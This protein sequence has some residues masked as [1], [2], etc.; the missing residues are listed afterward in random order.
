[1]DQFTYTNIFATKGIEYLAIISFFAILI[2]FWL[3]L[4]KKVSI[5]KKLQNAI[6]VLTSSV[7]RIP[8]GLFYSK[9]HTWTHLEKSGAAKV[10][11]DDLLLHITGEVTFKSLKSPGEFIYKGELLTQIDQNGKI[12]NIFSPISGKVLNTNPELND[13]PGMLIQDP[14]GIGWI[15]K[16]KPSDWVAETKSYYLAEDATKW[17]AMEIERFKDFLASSTS[18]YTTEQ[19]MLVLQDGGELRNNILSEMPSEIWND[20]QESFLGAVGE[21]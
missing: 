17:S 5:T 21:K 12:L 19:S 10:G 4:N 11:L 1:M 16:I 7:L 13:N 14:Y 6:G 20:F 3:I 8:Q 2:P 9:N 15:Y 18:K